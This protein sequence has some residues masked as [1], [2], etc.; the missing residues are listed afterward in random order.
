VNDFVVGQL[1]ETRAIDV[2]VRSGVPGPPGPPGGIGPV[3]PA[4]PPGPDGRTTTIVGAFGEV[5]TPADLPA[6][7][8]IP[9]DWDGMGQPPADLQVQI[10]EAL[11]HLPLFL[12]DAQDR[13]IFVFIGGAWLDIGQPQGE[14]G[15]PGAQ[16]VPGPAGQQGNVGPPGAQGVQGV[17]GDQGVPG[18]PGVGVPGPAGPQGSI[19][20][21]GPPGAQGSIGPQGER[22]EQ[23][24][25]GEA[26]PPSFP[27][28]PTGLTY[29]R[30]NNGW[31]PVLPLTGGTLD[32]GLTVSGTTRFLLDARAMGTLTLDLE[33][34]Q[35][36]H[37]ATKRYVDSLV[38]DLSPY[39]ARAGGQMTGPLISATG[40]GVTNPGL[41]IGD[42]STG[43]YRT[44]NVVIPVVSGQ[45]VMQWFFDSIMLTVPLN[46]AVQRI[47][48]LADPTADADAL[49]R[50]AGDA[51]YLS[52]SGGQMA[53]D[54][55]MASG[56]NIVLAQNPTSDTYAAPKVYVDQQV[57]GR[58]TQ[59]QGDARYLQLAAGGIVNGPVQ[60]LNPP[61]VP[62]D[63]VT[64]GYVDQRRAVSL[65][66]DLM[67]DVPV[68][69]GTWTTLYT[70]AYP[71]PR[72]GN[73][74]VMASVN[75]NT[76]NP[77]QPGGLILFGVRILNN[78]QRQI[79]GYSYG[80]P[81]NQSSGFSVDL[82]LVVNGNNPTITIQIA[83]LDAGAGSPMGF[84]VVGGGGDD[85]SQ[86]LIAD[87][88]PTA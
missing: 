50:R 23:G 33:P 72:G 4:G 3:G 32:G 62:N 21:V 42:N 48:N 16:G 65:L 24:P 35:P 36:D 18:A 69:A 71:I 6:D 57:G 84:T 19:G 49:N 64:K 51:R 25:T 61:V 63:V 5:R 31:I 85:R 17:R 26:G 77:T 10:G 28:A 20:P 9:A 13:H 30:L 88:G 74:R 75:V 29:G 70:T 66:I 47:Y 55:T 58:L 43:F 86:I 82:F 39:L 73:S 46:A 59:A 80:G 79:F 2:H 87:M 14:R 54:L 56:T 76:K 68:P 11:M 67:L 81:G 27:D 34:A 22:G 1:G 7:G 52:K 37:A 8:F 44:G 15:P 41:A 78:P 60:F 38:P 45:I 12:P 83:S 53:G 40:T